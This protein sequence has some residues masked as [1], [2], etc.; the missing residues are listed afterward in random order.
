MERLSGKPRLVAWLLVALS[1]PLIALSQHPANVPLLGL[2]GLVPLLL[3]LPHLSRGGAWLAGWVVGLCYFWGDMWWLGQMVTDPGNEWIIFAMF[4]FVATAMAAFWG[5]AAMISRWLMTRRQGWTIVLVPLVWL[6][7]EFIHEFNTPAPYPWLPLGMAIT[8]L[9]L[10]LQTADIWGQYGLSLAVVLTNLGIA[11]TLEF[12]PGTGR[13]GLRKQGAGRIALPVAAALVLAGG[14]VYGFFRVQELEADEARDGP[15]VGLVQGNLAQEVKV[16]TGA[17]RRKRLQESYSEHMELSQTAARQHAELICWAETMLFG[18][19]TRDGLDRLSPRDSALFFDNGVPSRKLL[20]PSNQISATRQHN[21]SF[22]ENFRA[23]LAYEIKTPMLV[24]AITDIPAEEQDVEWKKPSYDTRVYNTAMLFD[25]QGR[26]AGSYDKRY[27]V[28]GG[29]YIPLEHVGL[30][31]AIVEYYSEGLQG[32]V[33]RVEPGRRLTTFR[34]PSQTPRLQGRDWAF[35]SSIC[36][37]YAWPGCYAE[38]HEQPARYPD[39]HVN[40]SNEGWFRQSAEL[41]QAM[42]YCRLRCIESRM[43]ML[44]ATNTGIS[45]HIDALGRT[46]EVLT[47]DGRDREVKG[48]LLVQPAILKNPQPTF[49]VAGVGRALAHLAMWFTVVTMLLMAAGRAVEI[50]RHRRGRR[51]ES[52]QERASMGTRKN[53]ASTTAPAD[54][55]TPTRDQA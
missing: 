6:G 48:L 39:F 29:E 8:E 36:Y 24:G 7:I 10:F 52:A 34:L 12:K 43:P 40:I 23:R 18:G 38:L 2:L 32:A 49:F 37:E 47:V 11:R 35:T 54:P 16:G 13:V 46:R 21:T 53:P 30:V 31:R 22:A 33:S 28:P 19:A 20:Q 50:R 1:G 51:A 14:S 3:V 15:L 26:V 44:R 45:A 41:D 42:E 27:L 25:G 5:V 4:A 55:S 9:S 17:E